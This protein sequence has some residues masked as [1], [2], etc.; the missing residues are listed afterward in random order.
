MKHPVFLIYKSILNSYLTTKAIDSFDN[1]LE[2]WSSDREKA[3]IFFSE[4]VAKE[5]IKLLTKKLFEH[6][7][8][9]IYGSELFCWE[10]KQKKYLEAYDTYLYHQKA[11]IPVE[12]WL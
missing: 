8:K 3:T 1:E 5:Y 11:I 10:L 2:C 9:T 7:A 12:V 6:T 4:Q